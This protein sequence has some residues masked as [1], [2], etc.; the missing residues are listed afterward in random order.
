MRVIAGRWKGRPLRGGR[1]LV[2]RPTT[3]R[4][5]EAVFSILSTRVTG[6]EVADLYCG[7]G[8]LGIEALSRGAAFVHFVDTSPT[9]LNLTRL[10]LEACLSDHSS[11]RLSRAEALRWLA[12]FVA[13]G[14]W[15]PVIVLA[16]PPYGTDWASEVISL[17][18][19][20]P[21]DFPLS[22]AIVEHGSD[23][24]WEPQPSGRF[25]WRR[26]SYGTTTLTIL[27]G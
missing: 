6:S 23:A 3:D 21:A 13:D 19:H 11:F 15:R 16:D 20:A 17:L 25:L 7:A 5:K 12:V 22:A 2:M 4:V 9:A 26:R 1:G 10:N 8:G 14:H 24:E 27:E 18:Q